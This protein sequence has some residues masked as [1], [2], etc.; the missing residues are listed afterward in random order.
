[1]TLFWS[2]NYVAAKLALRSFPPL[3]LASLR[4]V[5]AGTLMSA[6]YAVWAR[7]GVHL[8]FREW[9]RRDLVWMTVVGVLGMAGNQLLFVTG[10]GHT[11]VAHGALII[12]TQPMLVL[13]LAWM[14]GHERLTPRKIA[15][16]ALAIGGIAALHIGPAPDGRG[17]TM[18]GDLLCFG[19]SLAFALYTVF[20]KEAMRRYGA[21]PLTALGY[22]ACAILLAGPVAWSASSFP[23]AAVTATGWWMLA[24]MAAISSVAC[25]II[26]S[27]ALGRM[28]ATRVAS[29]N[30]AQPI[31][32]SIAG[33][34]ILH[35]PITA[36][37][38][39]S[40]CMVLGGM[41]L[42]GRN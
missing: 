15:G 19:C 16:L 12:S 30:Y 1:M 2:I 18:L 10:M 24:Y 39:L 42:V 4:M 8:R 32:A 3:F 34:F 23:F 25:Y 5:I 27:Y 17:A 7:G 33:Y 31:I 29:F 13:L 22:A 35:E 36:G 41:W 37:I 28:A 6:L 14:R 40:G 21:M 26:Y 9:P 38:A 11:A 20:T